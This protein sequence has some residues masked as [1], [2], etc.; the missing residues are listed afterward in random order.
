MYPQPWLKWASWDEFD[1]SEE[2]FLPKTWHGS[3]NPGSRD[4]LL[5]GHN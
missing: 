1:L 2:A 4:G 3:G 5:G